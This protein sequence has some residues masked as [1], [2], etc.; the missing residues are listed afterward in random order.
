MSLY[1]YKL[2]ERNVQHLLK[3]WESAGVAGVVQ[4]GRSDCGKRRL[5]AEWTEYVEQTYRAGNRGGWRMSRA[6][7]AVRV[8]GPSDRNR[9]PSSTESSECLP[10]FA[11]WDGSA[12]GAIAFLE[13]LSFTQTC[14]PRFSLSEAAKNTNK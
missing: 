13:G 6:Q 2:L 1:F 8:G 10:G 9:R 3:A 14:L 4:R 12:S 11:K 7:V 5:A